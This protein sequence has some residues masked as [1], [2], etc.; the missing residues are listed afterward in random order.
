MTVKLVLKR[1]RSINAAKRLLPKI[2]T[3]YP[4]CKIIIPVRPTEEA[5]VRQD[6]QPG[7]FGDGLKGKRELLA[8][9]RLLGLR[10][11]CRV[12]GRYYS[13]KPSGYFV[14]SSAAA[15]AWLLNRTL[16]VNDFSRS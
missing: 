14:C 11:R 1:C 13:R 4:N 9:D 16:A 8:K 15:M 5:F 12:D 3:I 10:S 7:Q 2:R 6:A